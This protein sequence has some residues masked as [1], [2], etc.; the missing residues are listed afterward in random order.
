M[1]SSGWDEES[2]I[3]VS[4]EA[5]WATRLGNR[6]WNQRLQAIIGRQL[7]SMHSVSHKADS[8]CPFYDS[9]APESDAHHD[10]QTNEEFVG[11]TRTHVVGVFVVLQ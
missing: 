1:Q 8:Q 6:E 3:L 2:K 11:N 4:Q 7:K 9:E 10:E 5:K